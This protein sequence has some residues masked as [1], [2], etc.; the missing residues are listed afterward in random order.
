MIAYE[1]FAQYFAG[2]EITKLQ[3][4]YQSKEYV[5]ARETGAD[6]PVFAFAS[7]DQEAVRY[8]SAKAL[9]KYAFIAGH[10]LREIWYHMTPLCN[11]TRAD[12]DYITTCYADS[13]GKI[14]YSA[15]GTLSFFERYV[16]HH[17]VPSLILGSMLILA[18]VLCTLFIDQ[19]S[20]T[21]FAI[22]TAIAVAAV[23]IAQL[24]FI[25]NTKKY[26]YGNPRAHFYL[27]NHGVVVLTTRN[28]YPI[29]YTKILRLD[30]EAGIKIT[31]LKKVYTFVANNGE[32]MTATL[33]GI[34]DE[35]KAVKRRHRHKKAN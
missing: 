30:T 34:V 2:G 8:P 35:L 12:D 27:L 32:E 25:S 33:K 31:T 26:R 13:L 15:S 1:T 20:W 11:D 4:V 14:M 23:A 19:L 3:F 28:E 22:A 16:L 10:S 6:G 5:V 9:L 24:I 21:F 29:P 18:L 7:E 17:L